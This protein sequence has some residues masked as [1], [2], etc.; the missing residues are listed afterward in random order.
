[1]LKHRRYVRTWGTARGPPE[2]TAGPP[3]RSPPEHRRAP[4]LRHPPSPSAGRLRVCFLFVSSKPA[5]P[6]P[7]QKPDRADSRR[8][9][10]RAAPRPRNAGGRGQRHLQPRGAAPRGRRRP[11]GS[12]LPA[13]PAHPRSAPRPPPDSAGLAQ[14]RG[15]RRRRTAL[16]GPRRS[17]PAPGHRSSVPGGGEPRPERG[18]R[19]LPR[20]GRYLCQGEVGGH[21]ASI[22]HRP[23]RRKDAPRP[24]ARCP[25]SATSPDGPGQNPAPDPRPPARSR[26]LRPQ[27]AALKQRR[28][29]ERGW[30]RSAGGGCG[31]NPEQQ[32]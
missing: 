5:S 14:S 31:K 28:A 1:M 26:S 9:P 29:A 15:P 18:G 11:T 27:T 30:S 16:R 20:G 22:M 19:P 12:G 3:P 7:R 24:S 17:P 6:S 21:A 32:P 8:G 2:R 4:R 25:T 13:R 10:L 23:G